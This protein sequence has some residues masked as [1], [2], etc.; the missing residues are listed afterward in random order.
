MERSS[1]VIKY[2]K[3][4]IIVNFEFGRMSEID[5]AMELSPGWKSFS[6]LVIQFGEI[7]SVNVF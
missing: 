4:A 3:G 5:R 1:S 6:L 7:G 2:G